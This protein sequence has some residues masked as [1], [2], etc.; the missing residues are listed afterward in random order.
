[1]ERTDGQTNI[2]TWYSKI[3]FDIVFIL[4]KDKVCLKSK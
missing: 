1:M 3:T 2:E 4:M